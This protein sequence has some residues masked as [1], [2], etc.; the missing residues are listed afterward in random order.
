MSNIEK[1]TG[2]N[3][4]G[5]AKIWWIYTSDVSEQI[6]DSVTLDCDIT[7]K[8][9]SL[10][11]TFY[12]TDETIELDSDEQENPAGTLYSYK[13]KCL[14][15]QDRQ[16]VEQLLW[17]MEGRGLIL[18]VKDKNGVVRIY[19]TAECPMQKKSKLKKPPNVGGFN[20][21]E[22]IFS[23]DFPLPAFYGDPI[24]EEDQSSA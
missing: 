8:E 2:E 4:S 6:V 15:P 7:L 23:G 18:C 1:H 9:G 21:W 10:W 17:A 14:V 24:S 13:I 20:G 16:S 22:V 11:N 5:I 12:A 3:I 19:G